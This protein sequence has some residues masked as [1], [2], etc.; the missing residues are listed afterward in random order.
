MSFPSEYSGHHKEQANVAS[1]G[2]ATVVHLRPAAG[3][4]WRVISLQGWH[5]GAAN[6]NVNWRYTDSA[7]IMDLTA[8]A[9]VAASALQS[10]YDNVKCADAV[11]LTYESYLSFVGGAGMLAAEKVYVQAIVE[12]LTGFN[13][14]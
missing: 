6:R 3:E 13:T 12:E 2:G 7:G 11:V 9:S 10:F 5:D 8:A 14:G 4:V 1:A